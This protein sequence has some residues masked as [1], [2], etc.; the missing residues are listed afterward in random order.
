MTKKKPKRVSPSSRNQA[1]E[2]IRR[3]GQ[4]AELYCQ[5]KSHLEISKAIGCSL[6]SVSRDLTDARAEWRSRREQKVA[7]FVEEQLAKIDN[8]ERVAWLG[9]ERSTLDAVT[10]TTEG[11]KTSE[12]RRGQAGDPRFLEI[13]LKCVK[14]RCE[15]LGLN[16]AAKIEATVTVNTPP[17]TRMEIAA[18]IVQLR[19]RKSPPGTRQD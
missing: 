19:E 12:E 3:R 13:A 11:E 9:W 6:S 2:T 4:V 16:A 15:L 1:M 8:C 18:L 14:Q 5:G 7:A 10:V 17:P